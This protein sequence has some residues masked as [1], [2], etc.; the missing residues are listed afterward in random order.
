MEGNPQ[1]PPESTPAQDSTTDNVPQRYSV[2][3][4]PELVRYMFQGVRGEYSRLL[5]QMRADQSDLP[6]SDRLGVV[7][8]TDVAK[9]AH[10]GVEGLKRADENPGE[11]V[12]IELS[13]EDAQL[14]KRFTN[15]TGEEGRLRA[16]MI[17][18]FDG[19]F[20]KSVNAT[21]IGNFRE[22]L[23]RFVGNPLKKNH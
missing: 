15:K 9:L 1:S 18:E 23:A 2:R 10:L 6:V 22:R 17:E 21:R 16:E 4:R 5:D 19:A 3:M 14:L 13:Q 12:A 7:E 11:S 20:Q 8:E